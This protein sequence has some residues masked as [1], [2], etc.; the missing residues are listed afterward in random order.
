MQEYTRD[1]VAEHNSLADLWTII[2]NKVFDLSKFVPRHPGGPILW[3]VAGMEAS[4]AYHTNHPSSVD[5]I[6][7]KYC[8]GTV[9]EKRESD[10]GPIYRALKE[11]VY[12]TTRLGTHTKTMVKLTMAPVAYLAMILYVLLHGSETLNFVHV[13]LLFMIGTYEICVFENAH[14]LSHGVGYRHFHRLQKVLTFVHACLCPEVLR[15]PHQNFYPPNEFQSFV[16]RNDVRK[17]SLELSRQLHKIIDLS[18]YWGPDNRF[19]THH[20]H[21]YNTNNLH[22]PEMANYMLPSCFRIAPWCPVRWFHKHQHIYFFPVFFCA[23]FVRPFIYLLECN[24]SYFRYVRAA[25]DWHCVVLVGSQ[26]FALSS[27]RVVFFLYLPM[28]VAICFELIR[29][30]GRS[31]AQLGHITNHFVEESQLNGAAQVEYVTK[32]CDGHKE[33]AIAQ[34]CDSITY[35]SNGPLDWIVFHFFLANSIH[36]MEHHLFPNIDQHALEREV[37]PLVRAATKEWRLPHH[38]YTFF[39]AALLM[40]ATLRGLGRKQPEVK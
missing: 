40:L 34:I 14:D 7:D 12:S 21:H 28:N 3:K 30:L 5:R 27:L 6:L 33:W 10:V 35:V 23:G 9:K 29:L 24:L 20:H 39:R 15:T 16:G 2:D 8:I 1:Q 17:R 11:K 19:C 36:G 32:E 26:L 38:H 25:H 18:Q 31:S 13:L 4:L 37:V 22:D